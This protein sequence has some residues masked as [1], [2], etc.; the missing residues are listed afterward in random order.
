[1]ARAAQQSN[2]RWA[3][4]F[5][6]EVHRAV[7]DL[8]AVGVSSAVTDLS[9]ELREFE[10]LV[11]VLGRAAE[12]MAQER[13]LDPKLAQRTMAAGG[14]ASGR[15]VARA[16]V[17]FQDRINGIREAAET[18]T[19]FLG[20]SYE[21]LYGHSS[22]G[23]EV[24]G[25]ESSLHRRDHGVFFTPSALADAVTQL[26]LT[27][28]TVTSQKYDISILDPACGPATFLAAALSQLTRTL[29]PGVSAPS[30]VRRTKRRILERCLFGV[31]RDA[32]AVAV[33]RT[34][35][36]LEVGDSSFDPAALIERLV[37]GDALT[38][39]LDS[40][41]TFLPASSRLL[42]KDGVPRFGVILTNPPWGGIKP[43][44][45]EF[46]THAESLRAHGSTP[47]APP[48][49]SGRILNGTLDALW[50]DYARWTR[51]YARTLVETPEFARLR[52]RDSGDPDLYQ[53]FM[54]RM[55]SLLDEDGRIGMVIPAGFQRA[56]GAAE[57]RRL[58]F[59][60]GHFEQMTEIINRGRVFPIHGMF[61]FLLAT[62]QKGAERG[63][64]RLRL[65]LSS[66]EEVGQSQLRRA[67]GPGRLSMSF[68]RQA[69]GQDYMIPGVRTRDEARL[70]RKLYSQHP[71]LGSAV[72]DSWSVRFR[73]ELDMTNDAKQ[74]VKVADAHRLGWQPSEDG[75]WVG[76]GSTFLPLYE[77]RMI[78]QFDSAAKAYRSGS[79]RQALWEPLDG[80]GRRIEPQ[81]L[82]PIWLAKDRRISLSRR[83]VF[84]DV[85]GHANERTVLASVIP[86]LAAC[87]NKVPVCMFEPADDRLPLLWTAIANSFVIDWIMRRWV[88][89]TINY[90][91]W[92]NVPFPR[93]NPESPAGALLIDRATKLLAGSPG[94]DP[95]PLVGEH[96]P[97]TPT[98]RQELRAE[99]D[100]TVAELFQLS[101]EEFALILS[102]FP[103]IDRF[104][105]RCGGGSEF[106]TKDL[107]MLT[108]LR[109][110]RGR[111][112][113]DELFESRVRLAREAGALSYVP[114]EKAALTRRLIGKPLIRE[115]AGGRS[116]TLCPGRR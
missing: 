79:G 14:L 66:V 52:A 10:A 4:G 26:A 107:A 3:R 85:S 94:G 97:A 53:F 19:G 47:W 1:M 96:S 108:L 5:V 116:G 59:G 90:F 60:S 31:D 18:P 68:I 40:W 33:A 100:A 109:G 15:A 44:R 69:G 7:Q 29:L 103:L 91:Y 83:A 77:G 65:G 58:Y 42:G 34:V 95:A 73:R 43:L 111:R 48:E 105:P 104:Q 36:W 41:G 110:E 12:L 72:R 45:R 61:R 86:A 2:G 57:L 114:S 51:H 99:I 13:G 81:F 75:T 16:L 24:G 93:V 67:S 23:S 54:V 21:A 89:T 76:D 71:T 78:N 56:I 37:C 27:N 63:V 38:E 87:G 49:A 6:G 39:P 92:W 98:R 9:T 55:F 35:L 25:R 82:V 46:I 113:G 84:C 62:Y 64:G 32:T 70:L 17:G 115:R 20:M 22:P 80:E 50:K 74:F 30:R 101:P 88:S 112:P 106:I 102:D 28:E 8:Q 11:L